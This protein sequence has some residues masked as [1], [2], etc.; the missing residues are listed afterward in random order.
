MSSV[1][2]AI[3][4][5]RS[6]RKFRPE[7]IPDEIIRDLLEA[8]RLA[9]SGSNSQPWRFKVVK[10]RETKRRLA[11]AAFNQRHV[12][13]APVVIVCCADLPRYLDWVISGAQDLL[14]LKPMENHIFEF[15]DYRTNKLKKMDIEQLGPEIGF[16]VAIAVEHIVLRAVELGLGTCWVRLADGKKIKEIFNWGKN[17]SFVTLL[18]LG[19]PA[20]APEARKRLS[21]DKILLD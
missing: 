9:P 5:R 16:N 20:E 6:I 4:M 10:D 18:L 8:A 3:K 14:K 13:E 7:E 17:I 12:A 19:Y 21:L 1:I 11:E 2:E 15:I